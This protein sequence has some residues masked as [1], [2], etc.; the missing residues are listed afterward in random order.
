MIKCCARTLCCKMDEVATPLASFKALTRPEKPRGFVE[1]SPSAAE[2]ERSFSSVSDASECSVTSSEY[3]DEVAVPMENPTVDCGYVLPEALQQEAP[4][5]PQ[6]TEVVNI[7]EAYDEYWRATSTVK[8]STTTTEQRRL[9]ES[10]NP[11][12]TTGTVS[13]EGTESGRLSFQLPNQNT[14]FRST[15]V[16]QHANSVVGMSDIQYDATLT[17]TGD[18]SNCTVSNMR[19]GHTPGSVRQHS[20]QKN[21]SVALSQNITDE[22]L[23]SS[24]Y[25]RLLSNGIWGTHREMPLSNNS[26][27]FENSDTA[28]PACSFRSTDEEW[29]QHENS[30]LT[31]SNLQYISDRLGNKGSAYHVSDGYESSSGIQAAVARLDDEAESESAESTLLSVHSGDESTTPT[32]SLNGGNA[33]SSNSTSPPET[34]VA[35]PNRMPRQNPLNMVRGMQRFTGNYTAMVANTRRRNRARSAPPHPRRVR[36]PFRKVHVQQG[37]PEY[38]EVMAFR[39]NAAAEVDAHKQRMIRSVSSPDWKAVEQVQYQ[40]PHTPNRRPR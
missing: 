7:Y 26:M 40:F 22:S 20:F 29:R 15:S 8:D 33:P 13:G 28:D 9:S 6:Q 36:T 5:Q 17:K 10:V 16:E 2:S 39:R 35:P 34:H 32:Q 4:T 18:T 11:K 12:N 14:G 31:G 27:Y 19:D 24:K 37:D 1:T 25:D 38:E 21:S 23:A 30:L 3:P